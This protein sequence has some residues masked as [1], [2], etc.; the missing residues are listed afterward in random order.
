LGAFAPLFFTIA[1]AQSVAVHDN[2]IVP[3]SP[4]VV[5]FLG[6]DIEIHALKVGQL[7]SIKKLFAGGKLEQVAAD[8]DLIDMIDILP[9]EMIRVVEIALGV[10]RKD[11]DGAE[12]DE[13]LNVCAAIFNKNSDFFVQRLGPSLLKMTAQ[14]A[15]LASLAGGLTQS[16]RLSRAATNTAR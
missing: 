14:L 12:V 13:F 2:D 3:P 15:A 1:G 11:I 6:R 8:A 9:E 7:L 5:R 4:D 10:P 16:R